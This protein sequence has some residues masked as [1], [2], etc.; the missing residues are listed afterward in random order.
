MNRLNFKLIVRKIIIDFKLCILWLY[1]VLP[2]RN[3]GSVGDQSLLP[4]YIWTRADLSMKSCQEEII[5]TIKRLKTTETCQCIPENEYIS[6]NWE[7]EISLIHVHL[8]AMVA[9]KIDRST[10]DSIRI[11]QRQLVAQQLMR[12]RWWLSVRHH[13]TVKT[14]DQTQMSKQDTILVICIYRIS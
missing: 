9:K 10:Y 1:A 14:N 8:E 12:S 11:Y 5:P 2:L 3:L 4:E 6:L 7:M 13:I